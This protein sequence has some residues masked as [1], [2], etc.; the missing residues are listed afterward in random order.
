[1]RHVIASGVVVICLAACD[2]GGGSLSLAN[3]PEATARIECEKIFECCDAAERMEQLGFFDPMPTNVDECTA[4]YAALINAFFGGTRAAVEAGTVIYDGDAAQ[5]CLDATAAGSCADYAAQLASD[6][7]SGDCD[8][9]FQGTVAN[10]GACDDDDNV[11]VSGYCADDG[12]GATTCAA[13]PGAGEPCP[14]FECDDGLD[15]TFDG[16]GS[17]C[18]AKLADGMPCDDDGECLSGACVGADPAMGTPGTCGAATMC[19]G[20]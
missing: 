8:L 20:A 16:T 6:E 3:L 18:V 15:C 9:A 2:G 13:R 12:A 19:D 7:T 11:C 14:D 17:T 4:T 1:M 5:R 10:G